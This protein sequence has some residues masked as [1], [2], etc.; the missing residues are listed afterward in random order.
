MDGATYIE[1][2]E[3]RV[4]GPVVPG[5]LSDVTRKGAVCKRK[6]LPPWSL[7]WQTAIPDCSQVPTF[8]APPSFLSQE[9]ASDHQQQEV[10]L[11]DT[12]PLLCNSVRF[13]MLMF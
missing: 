2:A 12:M 8:T 13:R 3:M 5:D 4:S 7:G 1:E 9:P 10:P 6:G 11:Y